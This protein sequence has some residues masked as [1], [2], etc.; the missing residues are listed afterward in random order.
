MS[1]TVELLPVAS[2]AAHQTEPRHGTI[3]FLLSRSRHARMWRRVNR[4]SAGFQRSK[5]LAFERD[6][7]AKRSAK[8]LFFG[9]GQCDWIVKRH[10]LLHFIS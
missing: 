2:S 1:Q 9:D 5:V 8:A 10:I 6:L 3:V 7:L 4:V